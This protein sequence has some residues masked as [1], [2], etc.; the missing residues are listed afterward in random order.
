MIRIGL[1]GLGGTQAD[2]KLVEYLLANRGDARFLV[3]TESAGSASPLILATGQ[4]VMA[5]GGF[6]RDRILTADQLADRVA[7]GVVRFFLLL[8]PLEQPDQAPQV[9]PGQPRGALGGPGPEDDATQWVRDNCQPVPR[10]LWQSPSGE[11]EGSAGAGSDG[12][13]ASRG[14]DHT[15]YDCGQRRQ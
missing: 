7:G 14:L 4:P 13:P 9:P 2:P 5:L 6:G 15:L 1:G 10:E 12:L 11:T 3:A 8:P